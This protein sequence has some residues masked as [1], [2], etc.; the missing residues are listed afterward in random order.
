MI[1]VIFQ[2]TISLHARKFAKCN[3][4]DWSPTREKLVPPE[5]YITNENMEEFFVQ[6]WQDGTKPNVTQGRRFINHILTYHAQPPLN[7]HHRQDYASVLDVLKGL[8]KEEGWR[9]HQSKGAK[10]MSRDIVKKIL[11]AGVHDD[12]GKMDLRKLRNKV[13]SAALILCGWHP[14]DA[15]RIKDENVINLE[16]FHDRDGHLRPKFFF[17]DLSHNKRQKWKVCNTIGCGCKGTHHI[18]NLA[19]PYNIILWYQRLKDKFDESLVER[20]S[21]ISRKERL[22]HFDENGDLKERKFFRSIT[23]RGCNCYSMPLVGFAATNQQPTDEE[24]HLHRKRSDREHSDPSRNYLSRKLYRE[25]VR[26]LSRE[27]TTPFLAVARAPEHGHGRHPERLR[28]LAS[29]PG[30]R[31]GQAHHRHGPPDVLHARE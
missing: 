23:K 9:D 29:H 1:S 12:D 17:N 4:L 20:K 30:P 18:K 27:V 25:A 6:C 16:N 13:L 24:L 11:L 21:R 14:K 26:T 10:P 8:E 19:C 31:Q 7:K 5:K 22:R 3:E 2:K 15:W 28:V